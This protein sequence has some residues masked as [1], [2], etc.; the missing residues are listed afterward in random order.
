M[1]SE[2][3]GKLLIMMDFTALVIFFMAACIIIMNEHDLLNDPQTDYR[4]L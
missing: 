2:L 3:S 1:S 4:S